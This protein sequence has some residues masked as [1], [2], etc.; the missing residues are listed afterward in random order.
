M[1]ATYFLGDHFVPQP[2]IF[3]QTRADL[4]LSTIT[5]NGM[6]VDK[7]VWDHLVKTVDESMKEARK[8]LD[9]FGF[10]VK[11]SFPAPLCA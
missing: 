6:L 3:M 10:P 9:T 5:R 7:V 4:V 2:T 11:D 8:K 1:T